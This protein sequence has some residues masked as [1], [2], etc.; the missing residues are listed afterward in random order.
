MVEE[1]SDLEEKE[2][3][4]DKEHKREEDKNTKNPA[5]NV[6]SPKLSTK[7][8]FSSQEDNKERNK[9]E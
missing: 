4:N 9:G 6:Q 2:M 5:M 7:K 1:Q 3:A 8:E